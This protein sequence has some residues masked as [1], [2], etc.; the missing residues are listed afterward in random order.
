MLAVVAVAE[1]LLVVG[2]EAEGTELPGTFVLNALWLVDLIGELENPALA[3]LGV[4]LGALV[5]G[6]EGLVLEDVG[7]I[8]SADYLEP[9]L[10]M[11]VE[12]VL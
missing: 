8:D 2:L 12:E 9:I 7:R 1:I 5:A 3:F 4:D 6:D 10:I 11:E